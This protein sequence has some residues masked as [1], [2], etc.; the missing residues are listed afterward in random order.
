MPGGAG[1][2]ARLFVHA[3][4]EILRPRACHDHRTYHGRRRCS[5][6][7]AAGS[8]GGKPAGTCARFV[9]A[10]GQSRAMRRR[11]PPFRG[12][13]LRGHGGRSRRLVGQLWKRGRVKEAGKGRG[14]W[15]RGRGGIRSGKLS[16]P[17]PSR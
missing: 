12:A 9:V 8:V 15:L 14:F 3:K 13:H 5:R 2:E 7:R 6:A 4:P 17:V 10:G 1:D 16:S 11:G